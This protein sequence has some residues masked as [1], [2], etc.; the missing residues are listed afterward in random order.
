M[1]IIA[2][3]R[4]LI[5]VTAIRDIVELVKSH[6]E[7]VCKAGLDTLLKLLTYDSKKVSWSGGMALFISNLVYLRREIVSATSDIVELLISGHR[8][9]GQANAVSKLLEHGKSVN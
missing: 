8:Y 3:L 6:N 9:G 4:P 1:E 7:Y 5:P 2:P